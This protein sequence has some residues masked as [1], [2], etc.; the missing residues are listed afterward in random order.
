MADLE[1]ISAERTILRVSMVQAMVEIDRARDAL[2][3]GVPTQQVINELG[4]LI[5]NLRKVADLTATPKTAAELRA[6]I[7][8]VAR[9]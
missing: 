2:I 5:V 6:V 1:Q 9:G 7:H 3:H 8:E 4:E